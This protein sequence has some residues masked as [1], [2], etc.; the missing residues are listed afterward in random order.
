MNYL[1]AQSEFAE[2]VKNTSAKGTAYFWKLSGD[3]ANSL[4][5]FLNMSEEALKDVLRLCKI[6]MERRTHSQTTILN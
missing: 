4:C 3:D 1:Q 6:Y 2:T 5:R